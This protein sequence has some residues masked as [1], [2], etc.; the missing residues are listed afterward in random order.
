MEEFEEFMAEMLEEYNYD[1]DTVMVTTAFAQ[2]LASEWEK[3][4]LI[5]RVSNQRELLLD[6]LYWR[7]TEIH[8]ADANKIVN[9]F[10]EQKKSNNS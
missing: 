7:E 10:L 2:A 1:K 6:F 3:K 4:L 8:P 5:Q 9:N